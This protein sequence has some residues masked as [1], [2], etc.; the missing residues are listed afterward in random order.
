L[1]FQRPG[2]NALAISDLLIA[3]MRE[4]SL[5]FPEGLQY[6]IVYKPT[7]FI[8]ESVREVMKTTLMAGLRAAEGRLP[9]F[10]P[11]RVHVS[12]APANAAFSLRRA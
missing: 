4:L 7:E 12:P 5:S 2:S 3:K 6:D 10:P 1:I 11:H 8:A 9:G